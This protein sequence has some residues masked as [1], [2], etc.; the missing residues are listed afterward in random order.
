MSQ[1]KASQARAKAAE[2]RDKALAL[3]LR[4]AGYQEIADELD[5]SVGGA[6]KSVMRALEILR[7]KTN[8]K[9]KE[10]RDLELQRLDAML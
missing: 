3:R 1:S 5:M 7:E 4:G 10:V 9:A 8:E 2:R 6:Y